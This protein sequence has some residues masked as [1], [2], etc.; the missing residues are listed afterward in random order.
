[1]KILFLTDNFVPE[2]NAPSTRTYEHCREWVKQGVDVTVITSAPNFPKGKV[3]KG[4]KNRWKQTEVIDGIKV[5]RV[6]TYITANEGFLKRT[7]DYISFAVASFLAGL[8]VNTDLI[9]ATSPQFFTVLSG[10]YL[11]F[12][13]QKPWVMEVRDLWPE[14]IKTVGAINDNSIL[15]YLEYV[16]KRCYKSAHQIIT[17]TESFKK[18]LIDKGIQKDKIHV[19][20]NGAD[21]NLF[22][23][24]E[25]DDTL[26]KTLG[27]EGKQILGY[28]G[29]HGMAH[30]L[31]F[32]LDCAKALEHTAY[33]FLFIGAG[34]EKNNLLK[35]IEQENISNVTMLDNVSKKEIVN[36]LSILDVALV[37]LKKDNLFKTVIP[38]K[39]FENAA[40]GIPI[41]IGVDGE[42]RE[43]VEFYG[44][45]VYYEP[46][47]QKKFLIALQRLNDS[48]NKDYHASGGKRLAREYDRKKL[49]LKMLRILSAD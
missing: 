43:L 2:V 32:L 24:K 11:G 12:I 7:L 34:A 48:K 35:K 28:I 33:H 19:I 31:D 18:V 3:F 27:L 13:K 10:R 47:N 42:A 23:P 4:Y 1:M 36:Y 39:I 38:S 14:S 15:R 20:K 26:I 40:M 8:W 16:E 45:G 46:E 21:L 9:I 49:A 30:K 25:K 41:L 29:T 5:I 37:N 22:Q 44:V 6:W 17:V